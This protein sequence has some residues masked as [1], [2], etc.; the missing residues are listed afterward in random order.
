[1]YRAAVATLVFEEVGAML[2]AGSR[3]G[4][5]AARAAHQLR[6]LPPP[7][8]LRLASRQSAEISLCRKYNTVHVKHLYDHYAA[9]QIIVILTVFAE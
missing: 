5:V 7:A 3:A 8:R 1:M 6:R 2:G 9:T 4:H